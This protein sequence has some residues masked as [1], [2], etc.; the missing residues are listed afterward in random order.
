MRYRF[1]HIQGAPRDQVEQHVRD[2]AELVQTRL[3]T[4]EE[5]LVE[6]DV[7][8]DYREKR[9]RDRRNASNFDGR[10]VLNLPGRRM[11]N[12]GANGHGET[13]VTAINEAFGDLEVQLDKFLAKL[14]KEAAIHDY[15]HRPSWE[16]EGAEMLGEPQ[17]PDED[18]D[19]WM[20]E[21]DRQ[22]QE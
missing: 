12:I 18:P 14:K 6:L 7:R 17:Q 1:H 19:R 5:D 3:S 22:R 21:W 16:R 10:L 13:W 8:L 15:Q 11:P 2:K 4:F 9:Y 20:E